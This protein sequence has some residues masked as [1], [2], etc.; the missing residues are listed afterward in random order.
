MK[1][2]RYRSFLSQKRK[3]SA[4]AEDILNGSEPST[5]SPG[6]PSVFQ[7]KDLRMQHCQILQTKRQKERNILTI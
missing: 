3:V 7:N 4:Y 2:R 1:Q 6:E 5:S